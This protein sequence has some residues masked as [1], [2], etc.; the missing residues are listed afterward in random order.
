[1]RPQRLRARDARAQIARARRRPGCPRAARASRDARPARSRACAKNST[2]MVKRWTLLGIE[3]LCS[4]DARESRQAPTYGSL[5]PPAAPE[6]AGRR[7]VDGLAEPAPTLEA[8]AHRRS[9]GRARCSSSGSGCCR[10][11]RGRRSLFGQSELAAARRARRAVRR[12]A[13]R[14]SRPA[15]AV[16]LPPR[17][18]GSSRL[19]G[20]ACSSRMRLRHLAQRPRV[21]RA[22]HRGAGYRTARRAL[23]SL[24]TLF[25]PVAERARATSCSAPTGDRRTRCGSRRGSR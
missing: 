5:R 16:A 4:R 12:R 24:V 9:R 11:R 19:G 18:P 17:S 6:R 2:V 1:M 8:R 7:A 22:A 3:S 23:I 15:L 10:L 13:G 14:R 21:D 20:A 25:R